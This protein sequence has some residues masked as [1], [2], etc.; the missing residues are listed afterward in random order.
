VWQM[1]RERRRL[2][3][4]AEITL[5]IGAPITFVDGTPPAEFA[6][7]LATIVKGL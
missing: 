4:L 3:H 2:A 1:K 7:R 5:R 6:Q